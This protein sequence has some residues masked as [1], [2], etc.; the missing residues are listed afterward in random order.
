MTASKPRST[1]GRGGRRPEQSRI[2]KAAPDRQ[3]RLTRAIVL[4]A[5][6]VLAGIAWLARELGM[7]SAELRGFA[8]TSL[9][10][11]FGMM[12]LA[13]AGALV[14]RLLRR[15]SRSARNRPNRGA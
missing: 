7:D 6:A 11:V 3:R 15:H 2:S 14:L 12:V 13:V 10:L 4:G 8:V 9:W 1:A 5:L